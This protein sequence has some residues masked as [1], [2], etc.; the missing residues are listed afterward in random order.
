LCTALVVGGIASADPVVT[1]TSQEQVG[2]EVTVY[3]NNLGLVKDTRDIELP[4]GQGELRFMDV[5]AR[6][7]PVTVH[8]KSINKPKEFS[9]LEQNYEYDL[10]NSNKLMDKYVG[11][12]I[13]LVDWNQYQD[14]KEVVEAT[15]LSNNEG[16]VF[17]IYD[18]IYL[19]HPGIRV[20][21]KLP[22][23]LIAKPTLTWLFDSSAQSG[24][25]L[26]VSYLTQDINWKADYVA[27]LNQEDTAADLS[28]WVTLDN[29]SGTT[30]NQARLKLVAGE[31]HRIE[32]VPTRDKM[33]MEKLAVVAPKAPQFEEKAF[34][35]Y[36]I[37]DL[38]RRTTIKD[39]QTKQVSLLE[40]TNAK[41]AKELLVY[42]I[43]SYFSREYRE[44]NPKQPVN[45]YIRLKNSKENGLG[46]PMPAGVIRVY[47]TDDDG[48]S[49][50][51]GEDKIQHTPKD[52]EVR[53]K[54][55]EAFD[56][57]A[58]RLQTDFKR[59]TRNLFE[60][61][62]EITLSNHKDKE[63]AV[64]LVEPLFGSWTVVS[65]SHPYTK[66]DA[67]TIRF[68]VKVPKD[69]EIKVKYRVKVGY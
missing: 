44:E 35:E 30:Y 29:K 18:E 25:K 39:R 57:V 38:Q 56:V 45:V 47:K 41:V 63:V 15:V 50:F 43:R 66:V 36:H 5:A 60:S 17:Q 65:N 64:G 42:G 59:L 53:L 27:V 3:N 31:V 52:E 20:L 8:V 58:Q 16:Q 34:F 11:K 2:V 6:I 19:G 54:I 4:R 12:K 26:E 49:Q 40:A 37:Y 22:E 68:N 9:V 51:I 48:S 10:I 69:A 28:G 24:H 23:N 1:S 46:M 32:E 67:H 61:E 62:W 21:P 55:G 14:R 13:K 33:F 7:M